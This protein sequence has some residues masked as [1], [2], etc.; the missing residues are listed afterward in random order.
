MFR[1][2]AVLPSSGVLITRWGLSGQCHVLT[3]L[4]PW[5]KDLLVLIGCEAGWIPDLVWMQRLEEKYFAPVGGRILT[6]I[7]I[8][9]HHTD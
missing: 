3:L 7:T 8:F 9:R 4:Y 6:I 5:E 1:V 2:V